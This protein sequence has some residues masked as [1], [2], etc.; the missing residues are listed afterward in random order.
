MFD[1]NRI[2]KDFEILNRKIW[3]GKPLVYLDNAATTQKPDVVISALTKYYK[4]YNA[5]IHRGAHK[6]A[7][8]ATIAYEAVRD[9][10]KKFISAID[11][12]VIFT[13]NTTESINLLAYSLGELLVN[14]GDE[15]LLSEMEHHSNIIPWFLLRERKKC[16]IIFAP[17]NENY[18]LDYEKLEKL[19]TKKTKIISITH[20]SN[21]LGTV[22]DIKR[23]ANLA[24]T[25]GSIFIVDAAQSVPHMKVNYKEL[26]CDFLVFSAHKMCGPTGV[27]VLVG[28]KE[29]LFKIPP[30]LGGGEMIKKVT[31]DGFTPND[32]PWKFEAGTPN[33]ADVIAFGAALDYLEKIGLENIYKHELELTEYALEKLKQFDFLKIYNPVIAL[34][35]LQAPRNDN[36][37][38]AGIIT[39]S[40]PVVHP[41][42]IATIIDQ[43]GVAIRAGHHCAQ[44]LMKKLG[45]SATAR[46]SF[47]FYNTKAEIDIFAHA[48][49]KAFDYFEVGA[50]KELKLKGRSNDSP[51]AK[52][53]A[54]KIR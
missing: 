4:E 54:A 8:E 50:C 7:E 9:K 46:A 6:L 43:Y 5:N 45:V 10:V 34:S 38:G 49:K 16:K 47:Y 33:I 30:F 23:I 24:K 53:G 31:F 25:N 18:E 32:I 51:N 21:V 3:D 12:E 37:S 48:L 41:H 15:I 28:S 40:N 42:D 14:E 36:Y 17:I 52:P 2:R 22:N 29:L 35:P 27:G 1:L 44:P 20:K 26:G 39:F 11:E 19:I 13:R